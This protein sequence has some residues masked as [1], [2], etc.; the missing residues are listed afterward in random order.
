M[1]LTEAISNEWVLGLGADAGVNILTQ[2][3]KTWSPEVIDYLLMLNVARG[4][5]GDHDVARFISLCRPSGIPERTG[6]PGTPD[7]GAADFLA[8][9][10]LVVPAGPEPGQPGRADRSTGTSGHGYHQPP[11]RR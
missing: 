8:R 11:Q 1:L 10:G 9:R 2:D 7:P 3:F 4:H 6:G 5:V